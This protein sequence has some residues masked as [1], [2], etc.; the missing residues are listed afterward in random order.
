MKFTPTVPPREFQVGRGERIRLKD[1]GRI[2]LAPDEQVTFK[3]EKGGEY[4]VARKSWGFYA[5]PSLNSRLPRF[6]LRGVLVKSS[7]R[8]YYVFLV[9][10]GREKEFYRYLKVEE[11]TIVCWLHNGK[12]LSN[13]ERKTGT[14]RA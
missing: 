5:T 4:D 12:T 1:C 3:T 10:R 2:R 9:E 6:G 8:R 14:S 13:I 7:Q 11:E